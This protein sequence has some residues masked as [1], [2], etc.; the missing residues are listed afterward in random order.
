MT[1][2]NETILG[3]AKRTA[4]RPRGFIPTWRP[5]ARTSELLDEVKAVLIEYA[6]HL[7]LTLRQVF[8]R[9]VGIYDYPKTEPAYKNLGEVLNT[10]RRAQVI[11][12]DAIRD[13]GLIRKDALAWN[14]VADFKRSVATQVGLYRRDRTEGQAARLIVWSEAAGMVPQLERVADPY[15]VSVLSSG[16]FDSVTVKH[17]FGKECA[18]EGRPVEVLH[19][20]DLD[21]SGAHMALNLTE[22]A[23]AFAHHYGGKVRLLCPV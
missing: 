13:D 9:L 1:I 19:V 17:E 2:I 6:A 15:G 7:P 8:Y 3:G 22:D 14:G 23:A 18:G 11:D 5:Q 16:G 12:M 4:L 21:P 20:G 10:A